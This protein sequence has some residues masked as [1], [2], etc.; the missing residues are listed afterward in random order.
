MTSPSPKSDTPS[1]VWECLYGSA[2]GQLLE[3]VL[4]GCGDETPKF[5]EPVLH[6]DDLR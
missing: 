4:S 1:I 6:E 2:Y 5:L 3:P